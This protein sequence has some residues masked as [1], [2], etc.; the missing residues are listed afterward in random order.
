VVARWTAKGTHL[1]EFRGFPPRT[2]GIAPTGNVVHFAATDI[3]LI[4][5]GLIQEEWNTLEQLDVMI[6]LGVVPTP[7]N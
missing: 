7:E 6:Q 1:G 2:H 5:D 3:Y 4:K